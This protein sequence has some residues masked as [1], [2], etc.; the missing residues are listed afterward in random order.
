M[1]GIEL[2]AHSI[3]T[4][5]GKTTKIQAQN[6]DYR[7]PEYWGGWVLAQYQWYTARSFS[8]ILRFLPFKDIL[9]LY[10]TLHEAD[11]TKFY[12]VAD[13]AYA[14]KYPQTKLK[15]IREAAGMS[16]S[17]LAKEAEVSLR[18]KS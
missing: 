6:V 4:I 3:Q 1:S 16:Q 15:R 5:T 9:N 18:S 17:Q 7:T 14:R 13:E 8:E 11:I 10:V 12:E 2:A